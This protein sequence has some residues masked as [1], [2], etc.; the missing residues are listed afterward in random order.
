MFQ[1]KSECL[2]EE[3]LE[4]MGW[5]AKQKKWRNFMQTDILGK[6]GGRMSS[7]QVQVILVL[8]R[9]LFKGDLNVFMS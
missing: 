7:Q 5:L 3:K 6:L 2:Q 9:K 8:V 1:K 4:H